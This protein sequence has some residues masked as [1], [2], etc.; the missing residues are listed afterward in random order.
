MTMVLDRM[1]AYRLVEYMSEQS[2]LPKARHERHFAVGGE[3]SLAYRVVVEYVP[4]GGLRGLF[5]RVIFRRAVERAV[6]TT[7][8][9]LDARFAAR[10]T[11]S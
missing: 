7:V 6:R 2:G 10:D 5:D 8:A 4:R 11:S 1:E 3:Y 9:N